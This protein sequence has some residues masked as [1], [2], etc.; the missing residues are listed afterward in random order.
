MRARVGVNEMISMVR[1]PIVSGV[2]LLIGATLTN[3]L[4]DGTVK[5]LA[6]RL[7]APQVFFLSGLIMAGLSLLT[8]R[9]GSRLG[10]FTTSCLRSKA[11]GLLALRSAATVAAAL[12]FFYAVASIPLAEVFLFIGLMP[13]MSAILSRPLLGERVQP[14]AWV[15]LGIGILGVSLLFPDGLSGLTF[16]HLCGLA[17]AFMGT[18]SLVLSRRMAKV[19]SNALVQVFYPNLALALSAVVLLPAVWQPM[20]LADLG[21]IVLYSALLFVARWGMV[22]VMRRLRAPVALPLMNVQF[23]WMVGVGFVFFGEVPAALTLVGAA[24]VMLAGIIALTE[25][26]REERLARLAA[27]RASAIA[28]E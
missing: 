10:L 16:G 3:S 13:L 23:V 25:Q 28:A 20:S 19:E 18:L 4:A 22:L 24:L 2:L 17:G 1:N 27:R 8:A 9:A 15:G 11:P 21:L 26:A 12:G 5:D 7:Q 14:A 6:A